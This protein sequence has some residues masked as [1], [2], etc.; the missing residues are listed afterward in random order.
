MTQVHLLP[1]VRPV[2]P[3]RAFSER[4]LGTSAAFSLNDH[5][6]VVVFS[7]VACHAQ[8]S[9]PCASAI[10][11]VNVS[12]DLTM[13][14][15]GTLVVEAPYQD[16]CAPDYVGC[17]IDADGVPT[18]EPV[19]ATHRAA[20]IRTSPLSGSGPQARAHWPRRGRRAR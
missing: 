11:T 15:D 7:S 19:P 14:A 16:M 20:C 2:K 6:C 1:G 8:N 3:A 5:R 18:G 10:E 13:N 17:V 4:G 9:P 12:L